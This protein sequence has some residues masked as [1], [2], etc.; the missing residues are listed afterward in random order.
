[1]VLMR[2]K[3]LLPLAFIA[4]ILFCTLAIPAFP[5]ESAAEETVCNAD[6]YYYDRINERAKICY[7][8]IKGYYDN[9]KDP[10]KKELFDVSHLLAQP[11]T[12]EDYKRPSQCGSAGR[13]KKRRRPGSGQPA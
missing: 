6:T 4:I 7:T 2:R 8:L 5:A 13:G 9:R 12:M 3:H 11:A 1:M 10:S